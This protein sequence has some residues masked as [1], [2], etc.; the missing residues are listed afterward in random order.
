MFNPFVR[1][2]HQLFKRVFLEETKMLV[3]SECQL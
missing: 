3:T 1:N 2:E